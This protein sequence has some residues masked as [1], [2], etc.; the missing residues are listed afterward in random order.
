[1]SSNST[2]GSISS[3]DSDLKS[4]VE[5]KIFSYYKALTDGCGDETCDNDLCVSS[6]KV[7]S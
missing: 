6:G 5:A 7:S 4:A 3:S 2:S 1:M